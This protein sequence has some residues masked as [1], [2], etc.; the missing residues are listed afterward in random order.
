MEAKSSEALKTFL[1]CQIPKKGIGIINCDRLIYPEPNTNFKS[2]GMIKEKEKLNYVSIVLCQGQLWARGDNK[3]NFGYIPIGY[4]Q[5]GKTILNMDNI[6]AKKEDYN[7]NLNLNLI[8]KIELTNEEK[9]IGN[10]TCK[11]VLKEMDNKIHIT[12]NDI[13]TYGCQIAGGLDYH[14]PSP[15]LN[16]QNN[17]EDFFNPEYFR[18]DLAK[19]GMKPQKIENIFN[20]YRSHLNRIDVHETLLT[21]S[22][23]SQDMSPSLNTKIDVNAP[24]E[25]LTLNIKLK[26]DAKLPEPKPVKP[27]TKEPIDVLKTPENNSKKNSNDISEKEIGGF[28]EIFDMYHNFN[29][30]DIS[31]LNDTSI[32]KQ[33]M[34]TKMLSDILKPLVYKN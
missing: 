4:E 33:K 19:M 24:D 17:K 32:K 10:K 15:I 28:K 16:S 9:E 13:G 27:E 11:E 30:V 12:N 8:D 23:S 31:I 29:D 21:G 6:Q 2:I 14:E 22:I 5:D 20:K 7:L 1:G 3:Y 26:D 34:Y 25:D 18:K